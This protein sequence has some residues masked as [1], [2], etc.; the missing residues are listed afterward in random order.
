M[1]FIE[2]L[3]LWPTYK[4]RNMKHGIK[5]KYVVDIIVIKCLRTRQMILEKIR[6][7]H[8]KHYAR[9]Y[10]YC[11]ELRRSNKGTTMI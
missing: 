1:E 2:K 9:L 6:R 5:T 8:H 11:E 7:S 3:R 4:P 10:N